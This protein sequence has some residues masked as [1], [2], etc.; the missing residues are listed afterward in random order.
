LKKILETGCSGF[1]GKALLERISENNVEVIVADIVNGV[2]FSDKNSLDSFDKTEVV[3]HLAARVFVPASFSNPSFVYPDNI[4]STVNIINYS[5][6]G[7]NK[8]N[9]CQLIHIRGSKLFDG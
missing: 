8:V 2:D 4:F 6:G 7:S 3:G 1:I 9:L 5:K